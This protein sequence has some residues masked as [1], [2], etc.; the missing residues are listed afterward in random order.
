MRTKG[1]FRASPLFASAAALVLLS[2][3]P[4]VPATQAEAAPVTGLGAVLQDET[5]EYVAKGQAQLRWQTFWVLDWTP[6]EGAR[7]HEIR[8]KTAEG[9]SRKVK[10]VDKPPFRLE[11]AKG[12]NPKAKGLVAR[13]VQLDTVG[14]LLSVR[15]VARATDGRTTA[16]SPWLQVGLPFTTKP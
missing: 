13:Q 16:P 5:H 6:V 8:Y 9:T 4:S 1:R 3:A 14:S 7:H 15:V 2:L 10:V 12:D 11:V